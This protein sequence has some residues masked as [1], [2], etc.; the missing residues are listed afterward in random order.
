LIEDVSLTTV[1]TC[2]FIWGDN[3]WYWS[4][5]GRWFD[6]VASLNRKPD[7]VIVATREQDRHRLVGFDCRVVLCETATIPAM[8]NAA[9]F[10]APSIWLT[11]SSADDYFLPDALDDLDGLSDDVDVVS[12]G[13]R[14]T[15]GVAVQARPVENLW[16]G[17]PAMILGTSFIR[18]DM[19][20]KVGGFDGRFA[21]F[22]WALWVMAA[23]AGARF[24][25]T[26]RLTHVIDI[27]SPGRYSSETFLR[28]EHQKIHRLRSDGTLPSE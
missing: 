4:K 5:L 7:E 13:A 2:G 23:R 28:E 10:A 26:P 25:C 9:F 16:A 1:A 24:W 18:A 14:T 6:A 17:S 20:R 21:L 11:H 19:F 15:G 8:A 27:D 22:D 3:D 12:V